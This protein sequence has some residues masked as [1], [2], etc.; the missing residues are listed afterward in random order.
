MDK[1]LSLLLGY[2]VGMISPAAMF[3]K[4]KHVNLKEE[5]TKNL[6]ASNAVLLLGKGYGTLIMVFDIC[7]SLFVGKL[8]RWLFPQL[9]LA[10]FIACFG[11]VLGH[12]WPAFLHFDGGKGLACFGGM[13]LFYDLRLFWFYLVFGVALMVIL[14]R[15]VVLPLFVSVSFPLIVW[16][17]SHDPHILAITILTGL[18]ILFVHRNNFGR[19]SRGEEAPMRNIIRYIFKKN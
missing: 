13:V 19:V 4:L 18:V 10:G 11:A 8:A 3:G 9:A 15:S 2:S 7:K 5:G 6:G 12:I 14:N 1:F 17:T 16:F